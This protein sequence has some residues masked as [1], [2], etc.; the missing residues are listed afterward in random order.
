V[1]G[2]S[3]SPGKDNE[4]AQAQ[5]PRLDPQERRELLIQAAE[6]TF[7]EKGYTQA[8]LADVDSQAGVSKTLLYHYFPEGRSEIYKEIL[9]GLSDGLIAAL[10]TATTAPVSVEERLDRVTD[11]LLSTFE[12]H[13]DAFRL[14]ILEP[15]GSGEQDII[16]EATAARAGLAAELTRLLAAAGQPLELTMA[17]SAATLGSILHVCE[18]RLAGQLTHDQAAEV[19]RRYVRGGLDAVGLV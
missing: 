10:R 6:Q 18:L 19:A 16:A 2:H 11:T 1:A 17:A 5:T 3:D 14:L 15:W 13:P 9:A 7:A 8:G 12:A 4:V